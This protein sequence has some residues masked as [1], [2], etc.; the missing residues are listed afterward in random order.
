MEST[1]DY[2]LQVKDIQLS[3]GGLMALTA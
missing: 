3:F 2:Q 1:E